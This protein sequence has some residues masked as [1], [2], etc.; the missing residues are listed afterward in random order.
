MRPIP[1]RSVSCLADR[2]TS[3]IRG[4]DF[5]IEVCAA[6]AKFLLTLAGVAALVMNQFTNNPAAT[7][8]IAWLLLTVVIVALGSV[9][10]FIGVVHVLRRRRLMGYLLPLVTSPGKSPGALLR[11]P[12]PHA[13]LPPRWVAVR[14]TSHDRVQAALRLANP[15]P[16]PLSD[17]LS[18][19]GEL[20]IFVSPSIRGWVLITGSEVPDPVDDVDACFIWLRELSGQLGEVQFFAANCALNHHAWARLLSGD[21]FRAYAWAGETLWNQGE[22]TRAELDLGVDCAS[23]GGEPTADVLSAH[24]PGLTNAEKVPLLAARWS[25]DPTS[26]DVNRQWQQPGITGRVTRH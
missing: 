17:G 6:A 14:S 13:A 15:K 1:I 16:C 2:R 24:D 3:G 18:P 19:A 21:V 25:I 5:R 7:D 9:F 4:G 23:Y 8:L 20:A 10:A 26:I 11:S 22:L 12:Q